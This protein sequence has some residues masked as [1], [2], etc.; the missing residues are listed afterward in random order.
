MVFDIQVDRAQGQEFPRWEKLSAD[1]KDGGFLQTLRAKVAQVNER[2]V[3]A[4][5]S[6]ASLY[7]GETE[8]IHGVALAMKKADLS[9]RYLLA[10]RDQAMKAYQKL[11]SMGMR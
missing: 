5:K 11:S 7:A 2:Q 6:L 3:D 4:D 9:F 8:D 10:V 1:R